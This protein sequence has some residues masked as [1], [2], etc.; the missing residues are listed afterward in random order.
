MEGFLGQGSWGT[1]NPQWAL[2]YQALSAL[3]YPSHFRGPPSLPLPATSLSQHDRQLQFTYVLATR[4]WNLGLSPTFFL[5]CFVWSAPLPR[6]LAMASLWFFGSGGWLLTQI[7]AERTLPHPHPGR[8]FVGGGWGVGRGV[9]VF[10]CVF[11]FFSHHFSSN[12][13]SPR[14][15][16]CTHE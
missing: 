16:L 11:I 3:L 8:S 9:C 6:P 10:V 7:L 14:C 5:F 1:Y 13:P 12:G 15:S 2:Q 4:T